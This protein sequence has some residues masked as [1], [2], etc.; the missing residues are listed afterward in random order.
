VLVGTN[1]ATTSIHNKSIYVA[2]FVGSVFGLAL[3]ALIVP[4]VLGARRVS[5]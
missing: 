5:G 2:G 1:V 4:S 3:T